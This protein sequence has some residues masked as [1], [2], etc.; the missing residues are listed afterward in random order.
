MS[1]TR[2]IEAVKQLDLDTVRDLLASQPDLL[3]VTD[4]R[5]LNLLH[6]ACSVSCAGLGVAESQAAKMV[7]LLLDHGLDVESTLPAKQDRCTALFFAVAR[8][9]NAALIKLLLKR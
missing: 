4:R 6:L 5:E 9:R 8:G 1:K 3:S 2:M 7:S